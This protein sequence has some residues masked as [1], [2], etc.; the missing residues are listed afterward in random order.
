MT[1]DLQSPFSDAVTICLGEMITTGAP[2]SI[3]RLGAAHIDPV[4]A[5]HQQSI[6]ALG[7]DEKS[8]LLEKPKSF[9]E[10]HFKNAHDNAVIG[11]LCNGELVGQSIIL[12]PNDA[13]PQTGMTDMP[14]IGTPNSITVLQGVSVLPA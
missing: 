1:K 12:N 8:F 14:A 6:A 2:F 9:F 11:I 13:H 5:L 3:V 7:N 10:T 4:H